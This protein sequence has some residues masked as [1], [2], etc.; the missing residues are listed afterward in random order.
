MALGILGYYHL[1]PW[2][3]PPPSSPS[4]ANSML[5]SAPRASVVSAIPSKPMAT[6]RDKQVGK[7]IPTWT[8]AGIVFLPNILHFIIVLPIRPWLEFLVLVFILILVSFEPF[9]G[10][11]PCSFRSA[12]GPRLPLVLGWATSGERRAG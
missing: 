4:R 1:L 3:I 12:V 6:S 2:R 7:T 10:G 8:N 5:S 11:M 9:S